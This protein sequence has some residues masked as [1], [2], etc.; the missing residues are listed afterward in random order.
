MDDKNPK[1]IELS[2]T[3]NAL[4]LFADKPDEAR[5]RNANGV[6]LKLSNFLPFDPNYHGKGMTGGSK[7]DREV[8]EE[9]VNKRNQLKSIAAEIRKVAVNDEIKHKI[10]EIEDDEESQLDAVAEGQVLYKLHKVRERDAKIV[11]RKKEQALVK[12]GKLICESCVFIFEDY[13]GEIGKG[14][15]ECH[16]LY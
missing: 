12:F 15:I 1:I 4:P 16:H 8:F 7:L 5:F 3:L 14:Y 9:F 11:L 2:K 10:Y 6:T 13:Y